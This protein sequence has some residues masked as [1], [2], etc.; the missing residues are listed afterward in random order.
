[1]QTVFRRH[2]DGTI[3]DVFEDACVWVRAGEGV[4]SILGPNLVMECCDYA[5]DLPLLPR[6]FEAM[7]D[8]LT[9]WAVNGLV[10]SHADG[11]TAQV[12]R[13]DFGLAPVERRPRTYT[14]ADCGGT[15]Q[16]AWSDEEAHAESVAR[17]GIRGDAPGMVVV[18][19]DCYGRILVEKGLDADGD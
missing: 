5:A 6:T 9:T 4:V 10:F 7:R 1:M 8:F 18:C 16:T 2:N 3:T 12:T 13:A 14:C 11:R 17:F 19:D 15:F